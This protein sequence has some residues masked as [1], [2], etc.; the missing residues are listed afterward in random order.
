[1]RVSVS[2]LYRCSNFHTPPVL[3][4]SCWIIPSKLRNAIY[5]SKT[6]MLV[7]KISTICLVDLAQCWIV[8][9]G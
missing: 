2:L 3:M 1:M 4:P 8:M 7:I 5:F 9:D 6:G